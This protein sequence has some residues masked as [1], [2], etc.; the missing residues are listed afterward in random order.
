M[1]PV[2]LLASDRVYYVSGVA[3]CPLDIGERCIDRLREGGVIVIPF[4]WESQRGKEG[5]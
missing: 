3:R 5:F 1:H 2:S 4:E